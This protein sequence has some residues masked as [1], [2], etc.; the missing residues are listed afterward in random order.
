[1][2]E[3]IKKPI[4]KK[5]AVIILI[6]A[7]LFITLIKFL[8]NPISFSQVTSE[9]VTYERGR[10]ISVDAEDKTE[11][12]DTPGQNKG[13]QKITVEITSG[14][15][16]GKTVSIDNYLTAGHCV[17]VKSGT[18]IIVKC[19]SPSGSKEIFSVYQYDRTGALIIAGLLFLALLIIVGRGKGL[20]SALALAI[21]VAVIAFAVIPEIYNGASPVLSAFT[22]AVMIALTSLLLLNGLS[23]KT[24]AAVLS[25]LLGIA[26][27]FLAYLLLSAILSVS[28]YSSEDT[29]LLIIVSRQTSL[30][31]SDLLFAGILLA[32]LGAVMDTAMSIS[33]S[34]YEISQSEKRSAGR[35]FRS[36]MNIGRDMIGTMCQTLVLAFV[37]SSL[38]SLL[39]AVSYGTAFNQFLSSN[40]LALEILRSLTGSFAIVATVP[41][42]AALCARIFSSGNKT[43]ARGKK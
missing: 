2:R 40:Y 26:V 18:R 24:F 30:R 42:S 35:L 39:V 33:S 12:P 10:V 11:N 4:V 19:D 31:L 13:L 5:A 14:A 27:S 34:L 3:F 28:G 23:E 36:G 15:H 20:R 37:G 8:T 9:G 22:A 21:S 41:I 6:A 29:E 25:T 38:S 43:K 7:V 1:M 16:K 32:S 17:E